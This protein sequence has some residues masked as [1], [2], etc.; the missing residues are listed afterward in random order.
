MARDPS[1]SAAAQPGGGVVGGAEVARG[2]EVAGVHKMLTTH[3][4]GE[5]GAEPDEDQAEMLA[6]LA[7]LVRAL[8]IARAAVGDPVSEAILTAARRRVG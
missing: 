7:T 6:E 5:V 2:G 4:A 1:K 8:M 3:G